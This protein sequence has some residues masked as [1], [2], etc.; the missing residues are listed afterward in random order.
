LRVISAH[1]RPFGTGE[2]ADLAEE[3]NFPFL[4]L[5]RRANFRRRRA[6]RRDWSARAMV[7]KLRKTV[8]TLCGMLSG[9]MPVKHVAAM[10][11]FL[12]GTCGWAFA[13]SGAAPSAAGGDMGYRMMLLAMQLGSILCF[14]RL[15]NR[16]AG[17][18]RL[19]GVLGELIV[20]VVIGPYA[21]GGLPLPGLPYGLFPLGGRFP[22]SPE[23]YGICCVA[24]VV[25]L[26]MVGLETDI[27]LF[28]RYSVAGSLVGIGGVLVSFVF[29]AG[30]CSLFAPVLLGE[31]LG[32]MSPACILMGVITTATSVGITARILA[33]RRKLDSPEGVTILAGAV[34]DD[35]LGI[36]LLAVGMGVITASAGSGTIH[37][38]RIGIIACK[39]V[40]IWI[41]ATALGLVASRKLSV[42]LKWFGDR[43]SISILSLGLALILAGLFEEAGL[44]MIIG[45]YIMGLSLSR[46]DV[47]HVVREALTPTYSL[48]VPVFFAVMGM[49]VDVRLFV[50]GS[51]LLFGL[52]FTAV[53]FAAKIIGCGVPALFSG[54]NF[55]GA[56]RIGCGMLPRGEVTLIVAGTALASGY[57]PPEL[58]GIVV[59]MTLISSFVAPMLLVRLFGVSRAGVRRPMG[60][61]VA[62]TT[63]KFSFPSSQTVELLVSKLIPVFEAEG[64]FVHSLS[65]R[66]H[67][68][69]LRKDHVVIGFRLQDSNLLFEC[70]GSQVAFISAAL[71]EVLAELEKMKN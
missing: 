22:V 36:V 47:T 59:M 2:F 18:L 14:T 69:Q 29:G 53:S 1:L 39:A 26:F 62:G 60:D 17:K 30:L 19:P 54:F 43:G 16:L 9:C 33:E 23:L 10:A 48:L 31:R 66:E 25:L 67:I 20:G 42:L 68:Y 52:A 8:L 51:G 34:I 27:R 12:F 7:W 6:N 71:Y 11:F 40:G 49:M 57:L 28:L 32:L 70:A 24:A 56:L 58:F 61:G 65:R 38:G 44:A 37:W 15:G 63:M 46:T 50:S 55:L 4:R 41:A 64:F 13:S 21:L 3:A 45:A 5:C 35:V